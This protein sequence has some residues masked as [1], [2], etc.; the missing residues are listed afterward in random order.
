VGNFQ[1]YQGAEAQTIIF[2]SADKRLLRQA[3][4]KCHIVE[5]SPRSPLFTKVIGGGQ[6]H[7]LI[8]KGSS[9]QTLN[10]EFSP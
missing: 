10:P 2:F 1:N 4:P 8:G 5:L 6:Q 3:F 9:C 7:S